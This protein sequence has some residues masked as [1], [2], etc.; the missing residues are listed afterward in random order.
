[1]R[2]TITTV[3]LVLLSLG[4]SPPAPREGKTASLAKETN[5]VPPV[6]FHGTWVYAD[7]LGMLNHVEYSNGVRT[8]V[9]SSWYTNGE[10]S[11]QCVITNI[12]GTQYVR[13][14]FWWDTGHPMELRHR[15]VG[16][17]RGYENG[18]Y[19]QWFSNGTKR[20]QGHYSEMR[21][22]GTWSSWY[23]SGELRGE[24]RFGSPVPRRT[25]T[26][27]AWDRSGNLLLNERI[28]DA[29]GDGRDTAVTREQ[30]R[31]LDP[32]MPLLCNPGIE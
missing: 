23:E 17:R 7:S 22:I 26:V 30:L 18:E 2:A 16:E 9:E 19:C 4:C 14:M 29:D 13:T 21:P 24:A 27:K 11:A 31:L 12:A 28:A 8:E 6:G 20:I 10:L 5:S 3:V 25:I 32:R 15:L 1:M